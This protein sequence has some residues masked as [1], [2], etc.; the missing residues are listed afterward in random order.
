VGGSEL[1]ALIVYGQAGS[2]SVAVEAALR[3][4]GAP[5]ELR[6]GPSPDNPMAQA[7]SIVLPSGE[8]MTESA[9]ILIWIAESFPEARLGPPPAS[10]A[11][12]QFLRWMSFVSAAIYALYWMRDEPS[13][14]GVDPGQQQVAKERLHNRITACWRIMDSQVS[15][16]P[17]LTG[18]R[19]SV[20]DLYIAVVSRWSP[21]RP[22]FYAAAPGLAKVVRR[23]DAEP[24]LQ[25]LWAERFPFQQ[26]ER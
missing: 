6:E 24:G 13:R 23:V 9:A 25:R 16:A 8:M 17:Y 5:H 19:L 4:A 11:R 2:G 18:A 7:P 3:L 1:T 20:L 22:T 26:G 10:P 15:P 14:L 21:R 12:A